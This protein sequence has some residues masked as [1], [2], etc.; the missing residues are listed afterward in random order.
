MTP[1]TSATEAEKPVSLAADLSTSSHQ[2]APKSLGAP[3][4]KTNTLF[5]DRRTGIV[6]V[7][8][9]AWVLS[10]LALGMGAQHRIPRPDE[11]HFSSAAYNLAHYGFLGTTTI[12]PD[13]T[14]LLRINQRTYFVMPLYLLVQAGWLKLFPASIFSI[15]ILNLLLLV[16]TLWCVYRIV[17]ILTGNTVVAAIAVALLPLDYAFMF[18]AISA[19]PD[20]LCLLFGM[21]AIA[22]Y[23]TL[24]TSS[25]HRA[26]LWSAFFV[27]LNVL[28]HPNALIHAIVLA[29]LIL[30]YDHSRIDVKS[31]AGAL[32]VACLVCLPWALYV[33]RDFAAFLAQMSANAL[34]NHRF[35]TSFNPF[36]LVT[37]E[38]GR[39]ANA[40]GLFSAQSLPKLKALVLLP[41]TAALAL[42][43]LWPSFRSLKGVRILA[44]GWAL[45]FAVQC[46]FNQKLSVYLLHILP[47]YAA[48]VATLVVFLWQKHITTAKGLALLLVFAAAVQAGGMVL[49]SFDKKEEFQRQ[50]ANFIERQM[51]AAQT[52][53]GSVI[54]LYDLKFDSRLTEDHAL[55]LTTG[56]RPD[57]IVIDD[58]DRESFAYMAK[59]RPELFAQV[60][61]RLKQ[62]IL[63]REFGTY[64]VYVN[65][66]LHASSQARS[67]F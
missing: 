42:T 51:T 61:S 57:V 45:C 26:V 23:L 47:F 66:D 18:G 24:R 15:R 17:R 67:G 63:A 43:F 22:G 5:S 31:V 1:L 50:A 27:S 38:L 65:P 10:L 4:L 39:Y 7:V 3:E 34:N 33:S 9:A 40:Y 64:V 56:K 20:V 8:T 21:M 28:T 62:Y 44:V 11:G 59:I 16:P 2:V 58:N 53:N 41:Y 46:V 13:A 54:L 12:D 52:I 48:L 6:L 37:E 60:Q 35:A 14:G 25:F 30:Y 32:A 29:A 36:R 55:G 19:R 49:T